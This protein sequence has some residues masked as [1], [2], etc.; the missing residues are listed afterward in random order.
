MNDFVAWDSMLKDQLMG[1][2]R[3]MHASFVYVDPTP[4]VAIQPSET[5]IRRASVQSDTISEEGELSLVSRPASTS[6]SK[7]EPLFDTDPTILAFT[8]AEPVN[9]L[10]SLTLFAPASTYLIH[11]PRIPTFTHTTVDSSS[12]FSSAPSPISIYAVHF[13]LSHATRAS[14]YTATLAELVKDVRQSYSELSSLARVRWNMS[15]RLPW[16]LEAVKLAQD[17]A[18]SLKQ[19]V[20][21]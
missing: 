9:V 12:S 4:P 16:H 6:T 3:P 14:T 15:G 2:R 17:I 10:P 18:E 7:S 8:P 20:V 1:I 19:T 5:K 21:D 13:L 11:V